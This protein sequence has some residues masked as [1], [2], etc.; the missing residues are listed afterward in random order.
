MVFG[1]FK[2]FGDYVLLGLNYKSVRVIEMIIV[3]EIVQQVFERYLLFREKVLDY[4]LCDVIGYFI[5]RMGSVSN[6]EEDVDKWITEYVR[7]IS[8]KE[9]FFVF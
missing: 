7:V 2:V 1:I 3:D 4:V 8:D 9:K 6:V 5:K